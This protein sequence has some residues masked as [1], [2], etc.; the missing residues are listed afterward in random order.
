[1]Q[2]FMILIYQLEKEIKI[3][4]KLGGRQEGVLQ[5]PNTPVPR[6]YL[7]NLFLHLSITMNEIHHTC[8]I[9]LEKHHR[10]HLGV[11]EQIV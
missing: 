4:L 7:Y 2:C 1:M 3:G 8:T 9:L 10:A 5:F 11:P 6:K